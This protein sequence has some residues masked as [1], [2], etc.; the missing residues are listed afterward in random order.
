MEKII[1]VSHNIFGFKCLE[2]LI[3]FHN[4]NIIIDLIITRKPT[5]HLS[6]QVNNFKDIAIKNNI[7]CVEENNLNNI[8][9]KIKNIKPH[10]LLVFGWSKLIPSNILNHCQ[11]ALGTHPSML[12][13][14]KGNSTIPWHILSNQSK[15][16]F[17][18]FSLEEKVDTG[19]IFF[20]SH[21]S[22]DKNDTATTIYNKFT[23]EG[24][25]FINN[26]LITICNTK[27]PIKNNYLH[28]NQ[29]HSTTLKRIKTDSMINWDNDVHKIE[30][31]IRAM[32][33]PYP[34]AYS[35]L[36]RS[37]K[38][39]KICFLKVEL[40]DALDED[41]IGMNGT[42]LIYNENIYVKCSGGYLK[43]LQVKH[44]DNFFQLKHNDRF[45]NKMTDFLYENI[46]KIQKV[47]IKKSTAPQ[48]K[49]NVLVVVAHPDDE[50]YGCAGFIYKLSQ[51]GYEV[52]VLILTEGCTTQY[53]GEEL[54]NIKKQE[55]E[56]VK[57]ILNINQY[58]FADLPDMRLDT[59]P[60]VEI[61]KNI[62]KYISEL[63]PEIILTHSDNDLNRDH[64]CIHKSVLVA[65]RPQ[66]N[67]K[68]IL[69]FET[70]S[71]TELN[72]NSFNPNKFIDISD[73]LDI[74]IK[75]IKAYKS[76]LRDYPHGRNET[77]VKALASYRG[78]CSNFLY[79]EAFKVIKDY[80]NEEFY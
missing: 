23:E 42:C 71:T 70:L 50:V 66:S 31:L 56:N 14:L 75:A 25:K 3:K 37:K 28:L 41:F 9:D 16:G 2:Q 77:A 10:L 30:T 11:L 29:K 18:L 5:K 34:L 35:Y 47:I 58:Y 49:K 27:N 55:S 21:F 51:Y 59:L 44:D 1:F 43:V 32:C 74:K 38:Y 15:C 46:Y 64:T 52:N 63:K 76:E 72:K 57:K 60:E 33:T 68:K 48:N 24:M 53:N 73:C 7:D 45:D 36:L 61:T 65:A 4:K 17:S 13:S 12:P 80:S 26:Y 39:Y 20:Q 54:I 8:I 78:I 69:T 19:K 79:A 6:D 22:I 67:V 40:V 62:C